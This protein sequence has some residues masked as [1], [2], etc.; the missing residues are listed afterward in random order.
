MKTTTMSSMRQGS[1]WR[2]PLEGAGSLWHNT[3]TSTA[4]SSAQKTAAASLGVDG[5]LGGVKNDVIQT[6]SIELL[7]L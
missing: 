1:I 3:S 6:K 5:G 4:S 2:R 7:A